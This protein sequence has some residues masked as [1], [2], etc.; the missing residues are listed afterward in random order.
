MD[1]LSLGGFGLAVASLSFELFSAS[2]G[3]IFFSKPETCP[4]ELATFSSGSG[5]FTNSDA[6]ESVQPEFT[7]LQKKALSF[8]ERTWKYP[9]LLKWATFDKAR[10]ED[11][12]SALGVLN[13][14]MMAFLESHERARHIKMQEATFMQVLQVNNRVNDLLKLVDSLQRLS[15]QHK[16]GMGDFEERVIRLTQFKVTSL[17]LDNPLAKGPPPPDRPISQLREGLTFE[18]PSSNEA[19]PPRDPRSNTSDNNRTIEDLFEREGRQDPFT[20]REIEF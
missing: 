8:I 16:P 15:Q 6:T 5:T 10:F 3:T 19:R 2:K 20:D 4:E 11:L 7:V 14:S 9:Q 1:P 17:A 13:D 12:L 18:T